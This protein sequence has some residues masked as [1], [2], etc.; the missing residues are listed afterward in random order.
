MG[1]GGVS[2]GGMTQNIVSKGG[3]GTHIQNK[4]YW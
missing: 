4:D 2:L 3:G 1:G